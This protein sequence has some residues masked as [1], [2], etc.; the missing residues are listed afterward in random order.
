MEDM[1]V[2][3]LAAEGPAADAAY[4]TPHWE[5]LF[6]QSDVVLRHPDQ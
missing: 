1:L 4:K 3:L 5:L 2:K 6:S